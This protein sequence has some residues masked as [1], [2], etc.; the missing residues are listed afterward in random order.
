VSGKC[1]PVAHWR[2]VL[3]WRDFTHLVTDIEGD[4]SYFARHQ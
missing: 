2:A 3:S 1:L 4:L